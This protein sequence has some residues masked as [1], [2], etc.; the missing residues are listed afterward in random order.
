M[1][2]LEK[3]EKI[4]KNKNEKSNI[5]NILISKDELINIKRIKINKNKLINQEKIKK[6]IKNKIKEHKSNI[7]FDYELTPIKIQENEIEKL[8]KTKKIKY[9]NKIEVLDILLSNF[10]I[11]SSRF[12]NF[13][14]YG[15]LIKFITKN[16]KS[17]LFINDIYV[18]S[19]KLKIMDN[20]SD[21]YK[22]LEKLILENNQIL[23][24][25]ENII[26]LK[27]KFDIKEDI[28]FF[29]LTIQGNLNIF[30]FFK[31]ILEE[32]KINEYFFDI[33]SIF[34]DNIVNY[35]YNFL[36]SENINIEPAVNSLK[37][38]ISKIKNNSI[39]KIVLIK[40]LNFSA[41][42]KKIESDDLQNFFK[43][44]DILYKSYNL[45]NINYKSILFEIPFKNKIKSEEDYYFYE[46]ENIESLKNNFIAM[47]KDYKIDNDIEPIFKIKEIPV[48]N[49]EEVLNSLFLY[50]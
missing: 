12:K 34:L 26:N 23:F 14:T 7:D 49:V 37:K 41:I 11:F 40:I 1:G 50:F 43:L 42:I 39:Y 8:F 19:N 24:I 9:G 27:T 5:E 18:F 38:T 47:L 15:N 17:Y 29:K 16:I 35:I 30:M 48:S 13:L 21:K 36:K 2:L 46:K 25:E 44:L 10:K 31:I 6:N 28:F 3:A 20:I 45:I 22:H 4:L 33:L 32:L